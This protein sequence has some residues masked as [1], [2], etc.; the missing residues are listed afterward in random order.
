[1]RTIKISLFLIFFFLALTPK[2][3]AAID[4]NDKTSN[5]NDL[6]NNG[7]TEYT[8][9]LPFSNSTEGI[10]LVSLMNDVRTY[11]NNNPIERELIR[12]NMQMLRNMELF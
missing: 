2:A 11:Y 9:S 4:Y 12:H 10:S 1:M 6:T 7:G 3:F 8:T 5:G